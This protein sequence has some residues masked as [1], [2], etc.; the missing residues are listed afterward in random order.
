M[1]EGKS[2]GKNKRTVNFLYALLSNRNR[3]SFSRAQK[4]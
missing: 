2:K 3:R 4:W 1:D